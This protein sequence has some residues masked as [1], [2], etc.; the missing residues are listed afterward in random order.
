[1]K[2]HARTIFLIGG[3][4]L[5]SFVVALG[6]LYSRTSMSHSRQT[7]VAL[8]GAEAMPFNLDKTK[9]IFEHLANGGLQTIVVRDPSDQEQIGLVQAHLKDE[10][11]KFRRGDFSDSARI[12]GENMPGLADLTA[13]A[14]KIEIRY[15]ALSNGAQIRYTTSNPEL[16]RALHLWFIAQVSDHG[17][18]AVAH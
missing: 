1:M 11:E 17:K 3:V 10:A 15:A 13:G 5:L 7:K 4:G 14:S 16:V 8:R 2:N 9:H 6:F 12:H 18:H